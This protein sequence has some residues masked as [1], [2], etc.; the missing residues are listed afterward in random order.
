MIRRNLRIPSCPCCN[1]VDPFTEL[2][3]S[4][5]LQIKQVSPDQSGNSLTLSQCEKISHVLP[6]GLTRIERFSA[7]RS[8]VHSEKVSDAALRVESTYSSIKLSGD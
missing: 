7:A 4:P 5:D 3:D 6:S 8:H 1:D 2:P